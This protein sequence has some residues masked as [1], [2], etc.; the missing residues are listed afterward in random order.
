MTRVA[1]LQSNYIPWK[2]YFDIIRN[3]DILVFYDDVQFTKNDWRNRNRIKTQAGT[4]WLTVPT[5]ADIHRTICEVALTDP[6]WQ[7]KHWKSLLQSYRRCP[8]FGDYEAFFEEVYLQTRWHNLSELNQYLIRHIATTILGFS[9]SFRSS[10]E[11]KLTGRKGERLLDLL[12]QIGADTY[13]S[14]PS[15]RDYIDPRAFQD[16][17]IE[18]EYMNYSGYSEYPQLYPPFAHNVSIVDLLFHMG[19]KTPHYMAPKT[20]HDTE[21]KAPHFIRPKVPHSIWQ[22]GSGMDPSFTPVGP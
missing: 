6:R 14:G 21:P 5:G 8:H 22:W 16:A 7:K 1:V 19:P 4:Q 2:G 9:T 20:R 3:V 10:T 13:L 12:K 17:G 11:F 18:L 15:A